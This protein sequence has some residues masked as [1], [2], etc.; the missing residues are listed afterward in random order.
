MALSSGA[1]GFNCVRPD[2]SFV[3]GCRHNAGLFVLHVCHSLLR[4]GQLLDQLR[5]IHSVRRRDWPW[6]QPM[7]HFC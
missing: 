2:T 5:A 3:A 1:S 6:G 7:V 4:R